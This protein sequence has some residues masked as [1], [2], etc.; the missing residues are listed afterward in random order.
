MPDGG[1]APAKLYAAP[2]PKLTE[3]QI[4]AIE[5]AVGFMDGNPPCMKDVAVLEELLKGIE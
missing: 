4:A 1:N 3:A 2:Q 5:F